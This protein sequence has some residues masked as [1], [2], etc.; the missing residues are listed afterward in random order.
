MIHSMTGYGKASQEIN[1]KKFN[2]EIRTLNSKSLDFNL[3]I[4]TSFREKEGEIRA[5]ASQYLERGKVDLWFTV[6]GF[7]DANN[8]TINKQLAAIYLSELKSFA[9]E[10]DLKETDWMQIVFRMPEVVKAAEE[11]ITDEEWDTA[12]HAI[13]AAFQQVNVFRKSEGQNIALSL[14]KNVQKIEELL[15]QVEPFEKERVRLLRDKITRSLS[16]LSNENNIDQ[17]R[18]EEE[19]VY[20]LEK[21]DI[22]EEKTRL[23]RH[24][25]YFLE[26]MK[27]EMYSGKKLNFISQEMGREINTLGSKS[28]NADLQRIVVMMKDELEKIKE[29]VLNVL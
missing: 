12:K 21:L 24:C 14:E 27:T 29:M 3:K 23:K 18:F 1:N 20:Y 8:Y 2:V 9:S 28:N 25:D 7:G 10:H 26:T 16:E 15:A 13:V 17:V 22:S 4:P 6:E 5:L 11:N 19:L